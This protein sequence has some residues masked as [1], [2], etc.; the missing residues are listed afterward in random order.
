M[1][2]TGRVVPIPSVLY[3]MRQGLGVPKVA[4]SPVYTSAVIAARTIG[5]WESWVIE[6]DTYFRHRREEEGQFHK[7]PCN[8]VGQLEYNHARNG[9]YC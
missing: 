6:F 7:N 9:Q 1:R 3:S 8:D 5:D 2:W 4:V